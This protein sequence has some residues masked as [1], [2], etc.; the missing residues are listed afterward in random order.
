MHDGDDPLHDLLRPDSDVSPPAWKDSFGIR[1]ARMLRRRR[2]VGRFVW[3]AGLAACFMAGVLTTHFFFSAPDVVREIEYVY[4]PAEQKQV[5]S[6]APVEKPVAEEKPTALALEWQAA[7]NPDRSVELNRRAG[8][9]YFAEEN[10]LESALR[11]YKRFLA[12]CTEQD[13]EI[14][15]KDNWLLV[16]LK[17]ARLEGRRNAKTTG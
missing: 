6:A 12:G 10:D 9:R 13:L 16:S 15:P 7:E 14:S 3:V 17:S 1:T 2:T 8:D 11:C 5:P 4:L